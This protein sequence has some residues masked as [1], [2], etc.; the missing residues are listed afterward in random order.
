M[1]IWNQRA[2][3]GASGQYVNLNKML[4]Y[5][6]LQLLIQYVMLIS[7]LSIPV[8]GFTQNVDDLEE[9]RGFQDILLDSDINEYNNLDFKKSIKI[10]DS[11]EPIAIH[12][13]KNGTYK[14]IGDVDI[15]SL[16]VKSYLA[17]VVEIK[18]TTTKDEN[19]MRALKKLY[20]DAGGDEK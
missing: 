14:K 3:E 19:I 11:E 9:K 5:K 7:L 1:A 8:K 13:R 16:E 18:I 20:G 4:M 10:E 17:K 15:K 6:I 12:T 2:I